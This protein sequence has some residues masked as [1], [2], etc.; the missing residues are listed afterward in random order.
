MRA[1]CASSWAFAGIEDP[2]QFRSVSRGHVLAW[3]R[4]FERRDLSGAT[5]RRKLAALPSLFSYLCD[6]NALTRNPVEGVKRPRMESTEGK[7]PAIGDYQA[8]ALLDGADA[9]TLRGKHARALHHLSRNDIRRAL[10][11]RSS[12]NSHS[13]RVRADH[14]AALSLWRFWVSRWTVRLIFPTQ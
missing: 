14:P 6:S 1:T 8:R 2:T 7:T 5:I 4:D 9:S 10:R 12:R 3:R 11:T 13:H